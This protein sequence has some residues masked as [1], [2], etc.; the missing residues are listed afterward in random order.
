M[1]PSRISIGARGSASVDENNLPQILVVQTILTFLAVT[2]VTLRLYVRTRLIKNPGYDDW[3]MLIAAVRFHSLPS[4]ENVIY[5][6][7]GETVVT[8]HGMKPEIDNMSSCALWVAGSFMFSRPLT[9]W[10]TAMH[11]STQETAMK[12]KSPRG[13]FGSP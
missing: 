2:A 11:G 6:T 8:T 1:A 12:R 13:H 9:G 10:D 5:S 3:T 4:P 7:L